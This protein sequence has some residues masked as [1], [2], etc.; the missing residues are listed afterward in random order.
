ME[1]NECLVQLL[2]MIPKGVRRKER[3]KTIQSLLKPESVGFIRIADFR[4]NELVA[5]GY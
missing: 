1:E 3:K 4:Q 5:G 2:A